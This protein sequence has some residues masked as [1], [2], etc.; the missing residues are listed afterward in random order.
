GGTSWENDFTNTI[1]TYGSG[2]SEQVFIVGDTDG[3]TILETAVSANPNTTSINSFGPPDATSD[4][5]YVARFNTDLTNARVAIIGGSNQDNIP[6]IDIDSNGNLFMV[7]DTYSN[8]YPATAGAYDETDPDVGDSDI[9]V[10]KYNND[11]T[12]HI[13]STY[14]GGS[15][16]DSYPCGMSISSSNN[17]FIC[18]EVNS[19]DF[20]TTGGAYDTSY[21]AQDFFVANFSNSL[22]LVDVVPDAVTDLAGS[23]GDTQVA[24]TWTAPS[25]NG[26]PITGYEVHY[27]DDGFVSDDNIC[28]TGSCT[29]ATTGATVSGLTNGILYSF[30]IYAINDI[31][32]A[33][34]SNTATATPQPGSITV[35]SPDGGEDW[36]TGTIQT[37]TWNSVSISELVDIELSRNGA[38]G[39]W[40]MLYD[41]ALNLGSTP[42]VVTGPANSTPNALIRVTS[43]DTPAVFDVSDAVFLISNPPSLATWPDNVNPDEI[44]VNSTGAADGKDYS[45]IIMSSDGNYIVAWVDSRNFGTTSTDIYAQKL[46]ANDGS[47]LWNANDMPV[48][49]AADAQPEQSV[50]SPNSFSMVADNNGGA[51]IA[52]DDDRSATDTNVYLQRLD[53]DGSPLWPTNGVLVQLNGTA[54]TRYEFSPYL[55]HDGNNGVFVV[56]SV[57]DDLFSTSNS[58]VMH[59]DSNG[60]ASSTW[61]T[62]AG[63]GPLPIADYP[64]FPYDI[65][66]SIVDDSGSGMIVTFVSSD[67]GTDG[68]IFALRIDSLGVPDPSWATGV[69]LDSATEEVTSFTVKSIPDGSGGLITG[70]LYSAG[71][72]TDIKTQKVDNTGLVQW[73]GGT[74]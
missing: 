69:Q 39:P 43:V 29:D 31:G 30:Q 24:L 45:R 16:F 58:Y 60:A 6:F 54:A 19:A 48:V 23:A 26:N 7:A 36:E 70:Y 52:W 10:T 18:G 28:G 51:I 64:V 55:L 32:T 42:W 34:V 71:G 38:G 49:T 25:G 4:D 67:F 56:W 35:T 12:T 57:M 62:G 14:I 53:S 27:S 15:D 74:N 72:S 65:A 3:G 63:G 40:E 22:S 13:A 1:L 33:A 46:D 68:D 44:Q 59:I 8:D 17:I 66:T 2:A 50:L 11:L 47:K 73:G 37:I 41:D 21:A 20:P 5:V 61:N 9:V